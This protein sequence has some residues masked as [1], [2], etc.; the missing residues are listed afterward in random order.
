M[1]G[2]LRNTMLYWLNE[3]G[4]VNQQKCLDMLKFKI[5]NK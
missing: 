1:K 3:G 2:D 4:A 5:W